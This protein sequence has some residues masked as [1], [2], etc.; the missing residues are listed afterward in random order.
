MWELL[1]KFSTA[2]LKTKQ[3]KRTP[4]GKAKEQQRAEAEMQFLL[5]ASLL[6][7]SDAAQGFIRET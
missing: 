4:K 1:L 3:D 2:S 7:K 5:T 6:R